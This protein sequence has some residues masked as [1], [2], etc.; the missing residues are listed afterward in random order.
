[1]TDTTTRRNF[2]LS[3]L[4]VAGSIVGTHALQTGISNAAVLPARMPERVL[5]RTGVRV[6]ILGLGCG[7]TNTPLSQEGKEGEAVAMIE[8]ALKLGIRYFDT[9]SNYGASE[10]YLGKA[11]R[12]HRSKVFLASKTF[13]LSRDGVWRELER[14][15]KRLNTDFL[16]LW[17]LH[18]VSFSEQLEAIFSPSGAM[19][20]IEEAQQQKLVRFFGITGDHEPDIM[21]EALRRYPFDTALIPVNSAEKHF[22]RPYFTAVTEIT[23]E[24]NIGVIAMKVPAY[25]KF[26]QR[27]GFIGTEQA[28]GYALSQPGVHCCVISANDMK[29]LEENVKAARAFE[30]LTDMQ[31]AELEHRTATI[32]PN[33]FPYHHRNLILSSL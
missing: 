2:V 12:P 26:F 19:K 1:M 11:L 21:V 25:G 16:D 3:S 13:E 5:G 17:Q 22:P 27:G 32:W 33:L 23:R 7:N 24:R 9:A 8:R 28:I 15:L 14:S 20:A 6:P 4:A 18:R 31:L 29:Q 10:A 30:Q